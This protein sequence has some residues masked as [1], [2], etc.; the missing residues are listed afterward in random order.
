MLGDCLCVNKTLWALCLW[1]IW[2]TGLAKRFYQEGPSTP[3]ALSII[4]SHTDT[5]HNPWVSSLVE[6]PGGQTVWYRAQALSLKPEEK[7]N[8]EWSSSQTVWYQTQSQVSSLKGRRCSECPSGQTVWSQTLSIV[9][10]LMHNSDY[11][12]LLLPS[13]LKDVIRFIFCSCAGLISSFRNF[14]FILLP[15]K[16]TVHVPYDCCKW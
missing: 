12:I 3:V 14:M 9:V 7:G 15:F 16:G 10:S 11:L 2:T 4:L 8:S 5:E 1:T 6:C 13:I